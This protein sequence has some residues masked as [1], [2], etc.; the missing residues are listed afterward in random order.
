MGDTAGSLD[1]V[2]RLQIDEMA[3]AINKMPVQVRTDDKRIAGGALSGK[4]QHL[5]AR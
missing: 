3:L 4:P 2:R 1:R 5:T